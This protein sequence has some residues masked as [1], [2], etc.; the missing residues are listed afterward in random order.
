MA[1]DKKNRSGK[2]Q[3]R[4]LKLQQKQERQSQRLARKQEK[5]ARKI[6]RQQER[7][8]A[9][10]RSL[11]DRTQAATAIEELVAGLKEGKVSVEYG[12]QQLT[13]EPTEA[14]DMRVRA[15]Q[16]YKTQ[17]LIIRVRWPRTAGMEDSTK[18]EGTSD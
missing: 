6:D 14:V 11:L 12:D 3:K 15:R 8:V 1:K 5:R 17:S 10:Y 18:P 9:A 2:K 13:L 16:T 7:K 4:E